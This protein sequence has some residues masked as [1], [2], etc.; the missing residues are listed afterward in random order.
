MVTWKTVETTWGESCL[1]VQIATALENSSGAIAL[2]AKVYILIAI[3][4]SSKL[5][6]K[7]QKSLNSSKVMPLRRKS[8]LLPIKDYD[9]QVILCFIF[10]INISIQSYHFR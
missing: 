6:K 1:P 10:V 3:S 9:Q 2:S 7:R 8:S 5:F 4:K